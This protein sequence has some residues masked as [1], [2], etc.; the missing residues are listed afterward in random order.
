MA[1]FLVY[2]AL[3]V[4]GWCGAYAVMA[5]FTRA[6]PVVAIVALLL[7]T[8]GL[9]SL[10][11]SRGA[12]TSDAEWHQAEMAS[13]LA[14]LYWLPDEGGCHPFAQVRERMA[15]HVYQSNSSFLPYWGERDCPAIET[16]AAQRTV[17]ILDA[18]FVQVRAARAQ[19]SPLRIGEVWRVLLPAGLGL[20]GGLATARLVQRD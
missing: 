6:E 15:L 9:A 10:E 11:T 16:E 7:L 3:F 13:H 14:Y 20:L 1:I 5:V 8:G 4:V 19:E 18:A 2:G 17:A 12:P